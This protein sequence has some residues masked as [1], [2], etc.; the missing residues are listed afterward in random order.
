MS[1]RKKVGI[2]GGTFDP[3]HL[4]HLILAENAWEQFELDTVLLMP[5]GEPYYK[6]DHDISSPA[7]RM[8]MVQLAIEDNKHLKLS[9]IEL[10]RAGKTYTADTLSALSQNNSECEYYFIL[11]ADSLFQIEQWYKPEQ[12]FQSAILIA[13]VRGNGNEEAVRRQIAFL[14]EKYEGTIHLM[15]MPAVDLSS[16]MIRQRI[17]EGQTIKYYVPKDV[18]KYIYHNHLYR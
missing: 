2:L 15:N 18:E 11:G 16:S 10:D 14:E 6:T 8:K 1:D 13:A 4:A 7:H 12:I 3:I 5:S 9:T 17:M